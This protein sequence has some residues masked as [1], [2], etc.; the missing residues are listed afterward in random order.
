MRVL[1]LLRRLHVGVVALILVGGAGCSEYHYY[2]IHVTFDLSTGWVGGVSEISTIQRC[3]M[4]VSGAD[5][6]SMI[7]GNAQNCPPMTAAGPGT[8]VG[9]VEFST[10]SDSGNFTFTF[11]GYDDQSTTDNCKAAEGTVTIP[12][13]T[14]TTTMGDLS[15]KRVGA[16]CN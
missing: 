6:G 11:A 10:F 2:D 13:T 4:T 5:S 3:K 1:R 12:A 8:D 15:V 14:A 16:G 9:I 7:M